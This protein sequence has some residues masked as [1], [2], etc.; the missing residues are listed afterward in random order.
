MT[1]S[2]EL[3]T[4]N[5]VMRKLAIDPG[6]CGSNGEALTPRLVETTLGA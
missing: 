4:N 3:F 6:R 5:C 1:N 2:F